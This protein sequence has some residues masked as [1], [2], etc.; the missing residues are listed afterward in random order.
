M[1]TMTMTAQ[2]LTFETP[3]CGEETARAELYGLLATLFYAPP[4]QQ[5][6]DA[7]GQAAAP[8]DGVLQQAWNELAAACAQADAQQVREEYEALFIGLGKPEVMLYASYYLSGF[9][10][11]KPLAA[12]RTDLANL[13]LAR[14][15]GM[16]ESEDHIAALCEA[17]RCLI[18]S[19]DAAQASL[20]TQ[21]QFFGAHLQPWTGAMCEAVIQHPQAR[22]YPVVARLAQRFFEVEAQAF[23]MA[24][25]L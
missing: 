17:M 16:P 25:G 6:L 14:D 23:D 5:L 13:G 8:G 4:P 12:L 9:L 11:E 22:F 19:D 21:Q 20:A 1:T 18:E 24:P 2:A 3:D 7:I 10:M 15:D